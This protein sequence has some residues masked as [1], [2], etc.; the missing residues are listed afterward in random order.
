M[1][2]RPVIF[3]EGFVLSFLQAAL[4]IALGINT[5]PPAAPEEEEI[6][7]ETFEHV[8]A[9]QGTGLGESSFSGAS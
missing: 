7:R 8:R 3:P 6:D 1:S 5:P 9:L 4:S 2:S